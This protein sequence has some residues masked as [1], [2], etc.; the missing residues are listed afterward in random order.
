MSCYGWERGSIKLPQEYVPRLRAALVQHAE[1]RIHALRSET[2][3]L[4]EQVKKVSPVKRGDA[5]S[6]IFADDTGGPVTDAYYLMSVSRYVDGKHVVTVKRPTDAQV[7]KHVM[8]RR[9]GALVIFSGEGDATV[10]LSKNIVTWDIPENNH[11]VD[12]AYGTELAR[13]LFSFLDTVEW[14]SRTG[15]QIV[16]NDEYTRENY[17]SGGG[18]N[19]IVREYSKRAQ[20]AHRAR[21]DKVL[22]R[23]YRPGVSH[24]SFY[25]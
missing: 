1:Q 14:T 5:L 8:D 2:D 6:K 4:W 17:E 15:G 20:A 22:H 24:L 21:R 25:Q 23:Q 12:R 7:K 3:K 19:Y 18:S 13:V 16:G 9:N 10:S 11:A